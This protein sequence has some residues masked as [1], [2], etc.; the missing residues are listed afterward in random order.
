MG[1]RRK[2]TIGFACL[3]AL[4]AGSGAVSFFELQYIGA[5]TRRIL[6]DSNRN[7]TISRE[8][9][10]GAEMLHLAL[11]HDYTLGSLSGGNDSLYTAGRK[12]FADALAKGH[13]A[14][15]TAIDGIEAAYAGYEVVVRGYFTSGAYFE[16]DWLKTNYW[17]AYMR[18]TDAIKEYMT[19]AEYNLGTHAAF[20]RHNAYRAITPSL[21]TLGVVL[22]LLVLLLY[23]IDIYY[24][25]PVVAMNRS[26]EGWLSSGTPFNAKVD[27]RD[28][29]GE[30]KENIM[31]LIARIKRSS[32]KIDN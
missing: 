29:T 7:M 14:G 28:E 8:L 9:L 22:L 23:F 12:L 16:S 25:K 13:E 30:L 19:G 31:E 6:D 10:D 11:L 24:M 26:V 2:V 17:T 3:A 27:G 4:V 1:I 20:L 15:E 5:E 21:V 32:T 18:L